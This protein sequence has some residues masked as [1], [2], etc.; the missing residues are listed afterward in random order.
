MNPKNAFYQANCTDQPIQAGKKPLMLPN[1][2]ARL[3]WGENTAVP[4][5]HEPIKLTGGDPRT[6]AG[7][8]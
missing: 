4:E 8:R 1:W 7:L 5:A 6:I 2:L 3:L